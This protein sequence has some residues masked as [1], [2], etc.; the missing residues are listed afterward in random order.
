MLVYASVGITMSKQ[1]KRLF[2]IEAPENLA[3]IGRIAG[4]QLVAV[5]LDPVKAEIGA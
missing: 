1:L 5:V 2:A 4:S 3:N